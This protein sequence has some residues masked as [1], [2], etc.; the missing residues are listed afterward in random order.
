MCGLFPCYVLAICQNDVLA[1]SVLRTCFMRGCAMYV[2]YVCYMCAHCVLCACCLCCL[3]YFKA[4]AIPPTPLHGGV[5]GKQIVQIYTH[6]YISM[7]IYVCIYKV[8]L[9]L[10]EEEEDQLATSTYESTRAVCEC[11][12]MMQ[13]GLFDQWDL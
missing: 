13:L 8:A 4:Y 5:Q 12:Q 10:A 6:E 9:L 1:M 7:C 3:C 11:I 2:L